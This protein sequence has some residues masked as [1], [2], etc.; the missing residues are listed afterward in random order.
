M[1][2]D[3]T[4]E[5]AWHP[6]DPVAELVANLERRAALLPGRGRRRWPDDPADALE[7]L[8][9]L[10]AVVGRRRRLEHVDRVRLADM[11]TDIA[12]VRGLVG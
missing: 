6:D 8:A 9:D 10:V 1:F 3:A 4:P 2:G 12:Y 11:A 7:A 5:D